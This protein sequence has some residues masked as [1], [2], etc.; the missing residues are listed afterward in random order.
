MFEDLVKSLVRMYVRTYVNTF[1]M[2]YVR[3]LITYV[4]ELFL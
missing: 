1:Q 3:M 4:I 2:G